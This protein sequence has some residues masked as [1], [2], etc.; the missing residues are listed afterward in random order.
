MTSFDDE[1]LKHPFSLPAGTRMPVFF[2]H[3]PAGTSV[4]NLVHFGQ[5]LRSEEMILLDYMSPEQ[6]LECYHTRTP[7][8]VPLENIIESDIHLVNAQNDLLGDPK[9]VAK[10]KEALKGWI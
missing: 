1:I 8:R 5:G 7:P 9:D 10:L 3:V 2:N 6:N 4:P